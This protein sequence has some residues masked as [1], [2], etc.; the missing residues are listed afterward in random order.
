VFTWI[1]EQDEGRI[2]A[3]KRFQFAICQ[4]E[5]TSLSVIVEGQRINNYM[6]ISSKLSASVEQPQ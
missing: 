2:S 6:F 3:V 1:A 4:C 5:Q